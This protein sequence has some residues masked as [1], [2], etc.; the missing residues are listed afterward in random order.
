ME[1]RT[2][3]K[4]GGWKLRWLRN[5][6]L[7]LDMVA[8]LGC[9]VDARRESAVHVLRGLRATFA[10]KRVVDIALWLHRPSSVIAMSSMEGHG[11]AS[12]SNRVETEPALA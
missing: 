11:P 10:E 12:C 6:K 8:R 4:S 1:V 2:V 3:W 7:A 5:G 9:R